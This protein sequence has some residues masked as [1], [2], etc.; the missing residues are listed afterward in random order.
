MR[1]KKDKRTER[2]KV[3]Q[4]MKERGEKGNKELKI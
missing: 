3:K 1:E 2:N 4:G